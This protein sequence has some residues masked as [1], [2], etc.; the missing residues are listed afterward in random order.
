MEQDMYLLSY[1]DKALQTRQL[2]QMERGWRSDQI[3]QMSKA[4][5]LVINQRYSKSKKLVFFEDYGTDIS[6]AFPWLFF[7]S[8]FTEDSYTLE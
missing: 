4:K 6:V 8:V 5:V 3:D 1:Q 7:L 2:E